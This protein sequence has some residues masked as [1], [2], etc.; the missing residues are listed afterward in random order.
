MDYWLAVMMV[1]DNEL[2]LTIALDVDELFAGVDG[3]MWQATVEEF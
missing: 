3:M 2:I 1:S